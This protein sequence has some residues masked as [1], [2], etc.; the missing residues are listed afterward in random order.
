MMLIKSSEEYYNILANTASKSEH[1]IVTSFGVFAGIGYDGDIGDKYPTE[2]RKFLETVKDH[3][4]V[5]MIIGVHGYYSA[6]PPKISPGHCRH[7]IQ[8]YGRRALRIEKHREF[9]PNIKWYT[10]HSLHSKIAVFWGPKHVIAIVGSRNFTNSPNHELSLCI[11]NSNDAIGVKSYALEL[12]DMAT[13]VS[14]DE[15]IN[16]L[17]KETG[18]DYCLNMLCGEV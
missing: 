11:S 13:P 17:I 1:G 3:T 2:E 9:Y 7:C 10:L 15:M 8:A 16:F 5:S 14:L 18:N 12:R 4:D 6:F